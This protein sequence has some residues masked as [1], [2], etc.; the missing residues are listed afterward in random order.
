MKRGGQLR[1]GVSGWR[2]AGGEK[3]LPERLAATSQSLLTAG[4]VSRQL[5]YFSSEMPL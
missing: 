3:V 4:A 2:Y 1:I 5:Q